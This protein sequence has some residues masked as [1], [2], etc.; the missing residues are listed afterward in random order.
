MNGDTYLGI[1]FQ[2]AIASIEPRSVH[3]TLKRSP[4]GGESWATE[5]V[6]CY[7]G[8]CDIS[9]ACNCYLPMDI[10]LRPWCI[11]AALSQHTIPG[12]DTSG[13][14]EADHALETVR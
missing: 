14:S 8:G 5:S 2:N 13:F 6:A 4:N 3:T 7:Y 11:I 1:L 12:Q 10:N 9:I